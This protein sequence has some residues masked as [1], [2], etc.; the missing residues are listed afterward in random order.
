MQAELREG[1]LQKKLSISVP[2]C[3]DS[4]AGSVTLGKKPWVVIISKKM[5]NIG[6]RFIFS[7]LILKS[8]PKITSLLVFQFTNCRSNFV[9]KLL[10]TVIQVTWMSIYI[11]ELN[12]FVQVYI[13]PSI[14]TPSQISKRLYSGKKYDHMQCPGKW[15]GRHENCT[16]PLEVLNY[17]PQVVINYDHRFPATMSLERELH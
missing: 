10:I 13:I 2:E 1:T 12:I 3:F 9:N 5:L 7:R 4:L 8:P 17:I 15:Q 11:S 16:P 14:N 6:L